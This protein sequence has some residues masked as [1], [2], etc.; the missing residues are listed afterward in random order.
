M[1][2][3]P[4]LSSGPLLVMRRLAA[5]RAA[6]RRREDAAARSASRLLALGR[7]RHDGLTA[8]LH[9]A[10]LAAI[11]L[12]GLAALFKAVGAGLRRFDDRRA[13]LTFVKT[14]VS[15]LLGRVDGETGSG[16]SRGSV[17]NIRVRQ[18]ARVAPLRGADSRAVVEHKATASGSIEAR[19]STDGR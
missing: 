16:R 15:L 1:G 13:V 17:I 7:L 5:R 19:N 18:R 10:G 3:Q 11:S 2:P 14:H 8:L 4:H 12:F 9:A 6:M